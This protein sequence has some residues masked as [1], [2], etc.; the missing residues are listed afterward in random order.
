[1][2]EAV[3]GIDISYAQGHDTDFD[4]VRAAGFAFAFLRV[5]DGLTSLD[6]TT[7]G[8]IQRAQ[9]AGLLAGVYQFFRP[10]RDA[11]SQAALVLSQHRHFAAPFLPPVIDVEVGDDVPPAEVAAKIKV[12]TRMV[13]EEIGRDPIIY[14]GPGPW[15][16]YVKSTAFDSCPLWVAAYGFQA[17]PLPIGWRKWHF[18]QHSDKGRVPGVRG[19]VDL[20]LWNGSWSELQEFAEGVCR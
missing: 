14:C 3:K 12:W 17:P 1:M 13:R 10:K 16:A 20:N 2:A 9:E 8:N 18:W 5:S 6:A 11:L 19:N 4:A 15:S 7:G